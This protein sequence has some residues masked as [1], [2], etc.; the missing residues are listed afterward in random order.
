VPSDQE[1]R[2]TYQ[3]SISIGLIYCKFN[4][5]AKIWVIGSKKHEV[6]LKNEFEVEIMCLY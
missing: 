5:K 4:W 1:E 2:L 3:N 6:G